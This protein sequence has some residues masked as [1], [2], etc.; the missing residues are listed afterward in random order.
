[1]VYHSPIESVFAFNYTFY[2]SKRKQNSYK[3]QI[4]QITAS[5]QTS[6]S[7]LSKRTVISKGIPISEEPNDPFC[8]TVSS[9]WVRDTK[10][11]WPARQYTHTHRHTH[12]LKKIILSN[13]NYSLQQK[14][15]LYNPFMVFI[16]C[17]RHIW[18]QIYFSILE[19]L[20]KSCHFPKANVLIFEGSL[21]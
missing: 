8:H 4:K 21:I 18:C 3:E 6:V 10:S 13:S 15:Y 5:P 19:V 11:Y 20:F 17:I 1:M 2:H 14:R 12:T 9:H 16:I 7:H